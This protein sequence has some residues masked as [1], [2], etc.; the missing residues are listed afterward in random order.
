MAS[1]NLTYGEIDFETVYKSFKWIQKK[2]RNKDKDCWHNAFNK[3]GGVFIDLGHGTGKGVLSGCLIHGFE[4]CR[5]IELL[6]N[7]YKQSLKMKQGYERYVD[8]L[9]EQEYC[10]LHAP[11]C[12]EV[13]HG[14]ILKLDW[15]EAD[16]ILANSTC[17]SY[18]LL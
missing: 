2:H 7:L 13:E 18:Q 3:P 12:F 14:N 5:G 11:P 8:T 1:P 16:F 6:E 10:L 4:T 15:S 17:F 9:D